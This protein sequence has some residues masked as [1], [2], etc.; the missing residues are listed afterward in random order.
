RLQN[1]LKSYG[2]PADNFNSSIN[3]L[4]KRLLEN[5]FPHEIGFFLGYPYEDVLG[6]INYN[7][8]NECISGKWKVYSDVEKAK[9]IFK[10]YDYAKLVTK[11]LSLQG[12]NLFDIINYFKE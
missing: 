10:K 2:Y 9:D 11:R 3:F 1:A 7:G 12:N 8:K 5:E 4:K 6:F